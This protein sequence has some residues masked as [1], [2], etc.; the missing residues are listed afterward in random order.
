MKLL[1]A[2]NLAILIAAV[3]CPPPITK[4]ST[5]GAGGETF[6]AGPNDGSSLSTGSSSMPPRPETTTDMEMSTTDPDGGEGPFLYLISLVLDYF[7][8]IIE[9]ILGVFGSLF[10]M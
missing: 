9:A 7:K 6:T 8:N 3:V 5:D 10:G 2:L 4:V 1:L